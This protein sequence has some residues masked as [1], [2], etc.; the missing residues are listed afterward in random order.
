MNN[1]EKGSRYED[2]A[3]SFFISLGYEILEQNYRQK[4]G[5]IDLIA[6]DGKTIVFTE[7]KYRKN[8]RKGYPEEAVNYNKQKRIMR[9]AEWY[10]KEHRIQFD[11]PCR[12]DVISILDGEL[13]HFINAFGG[14]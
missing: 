13:K 7:V 14:F 3:A 6:K 4:T 12:F 9:T 10:L 5:E 1:R 2:Q 8:L 11:H